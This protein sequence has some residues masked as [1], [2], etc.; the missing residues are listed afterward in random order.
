MESICKDQGIGT[1]T[2]RVEV[3][4]FSIGEMVSRELCKFKAAG[5][6]RLIELISKKSHKVGTIWDIILGL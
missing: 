5:A 1:S 4:P 6:E 3:L 2:K